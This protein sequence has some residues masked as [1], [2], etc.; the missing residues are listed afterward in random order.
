[1]RY[2]IYGAGGIGGSIGARLFQQGHDVVLIARGAHLEALQRDGLQFETPASSVVIRIPAVGSPAE[3]NVADSDVVV[4]A[5]KTQDTTDALDSLAALTGSGTTIVCAQ[6]G[7][8]NERLALRRFRN[9]YG[10]YVIAPGEHLSPGLV[11]NYFTPVS[12]LLDLGRFPGGVDE[13]ADQIARDIANV[14]FLSRA[15]PDV[16]RWKYSKLLGNLVNAVEALCGRG[17]RTRGIADRARAEG[18]ACYEAANI[19]FASDAEVHER[20]AGL[21]AL[22]SFGDSVRMGGSSW[23]S[24]ARGTGSI[25]ADYLNGEIV[26][27]GR[28]HGIPTPVNAVLQREAMRAARERAKPG[29]MTI[30][31]LEARIA[32][33]S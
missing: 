19:A 22:G 16:M 12:G 10:M 15:V 17:D 27:L 25:E 8:E 21:P 24:L 4:M 7:V 31:A 29:S 18:V 30:E 33:T 5:M 9:V 3:A 2:V 23:Q 26:L 28:L 20:H 1:M 13:R 6:N 14:G 32:A 11:R